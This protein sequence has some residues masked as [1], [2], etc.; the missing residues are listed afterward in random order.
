MRYLISLFIITLIV[1]YSY[2]KNIPSPPTLKQ[3]PVE[4][5]QYLSTIANNFNNFTIVTTN[6][7][8][9][10]NGKY[11]DMVIYASGASFYISICVS[12]PKG[13]VWEKTLLTP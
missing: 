4:E 3:I 2:A 1:S 6:P 8:G 5:Q 11:G 7:N 13:T 10:R 12:E 9:N